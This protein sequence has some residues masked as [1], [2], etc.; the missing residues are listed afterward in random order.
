MQGLSVKSFLVGG[1]IASIIWLGFFVLITLESRKPS[2][3]H[4]APNFQLYG[5]VVTENRQ[6]YDA[7]AKVS[8]LT[9]TGNPPISIVDVRR[10]DENRWQVVVE[11]G[12]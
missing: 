11:K 9:V 4:W 8:L 10:I 12:Y 7:D 1:F 6:L 3:E 5:N 2:P